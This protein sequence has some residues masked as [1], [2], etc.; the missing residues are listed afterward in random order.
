[1]QQKNP[2]TLYQHLGL[3]PTAPARATKQK[4]SQ[5]WWLVLLVPALLSTK[6]TQQKILLHMNVCYISCCLPCIGFTYSF[7]TVRVTLQCT[8]TFVMFQHHISET[9]FLLCIGKTKSPPLLGFYQN[10][11]ILPTLNIGP[12]QILHSLYVVW[13]V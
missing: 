9:S 4:N 7:V 6:F 3:V 11:Q 5:S 1:M 10:P 8:H 13:F 12:P 2:N